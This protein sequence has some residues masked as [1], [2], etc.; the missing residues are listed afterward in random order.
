MEDFSSLEEEKGIDISHF[1][2][3]EYVAWQMG[4]DSVKQKEKHLGLEDG[5]TSSDE[6][7][8]LYDFDNIKNRNEVPRLLQSLIN[9]IETEGGSLDS[10]R[11]LNYYK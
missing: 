7:I 5:P 2:S 1:P 4:I 10:A 8:H 11:F 6:V 3:H 9:G